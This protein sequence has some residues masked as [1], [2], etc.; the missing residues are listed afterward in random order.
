[1]LPPEANFLSFEFQTQLHSPSLPTG[2]RYS[3]GKAAG[4]LPG[5]QSGWV[6]LMVL[7]SLSLE[8]TVIWS[9]SSAS[10]T[11]LRIA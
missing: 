10:Y 6:N 1:M 5:P 7:E 4:L 8:F 11:G 3:S 9:V 2:V